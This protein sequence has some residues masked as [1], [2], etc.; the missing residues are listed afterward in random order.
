[1]IYDS[2]VR[3]GNFANFWTLNQN[4][5]GGVRGRNGQDSGEWDQVIPFLYRTKIPVNP[6][7]WGP[8]PLGRRLDRPACASETSSQET[9]SSS[10][11][12]ANFQFLNSIA[13]A[14]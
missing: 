7:S 12:S 11:E 13:T 8:H 6:F 5:L 1:M 14:A 2:A 10:G 9:L 3:S 4:E